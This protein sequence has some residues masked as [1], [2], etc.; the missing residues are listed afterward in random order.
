[1]IFGVIAN[2]GEVIVENRIGNSMEDR[3]FLIAFGA[4]GV[5]VAVYGAFLGRLSF[6]WGRRLGFIENQCYQCGYD[7]SGSLSAGREN[8]PECGTLCWRYWRH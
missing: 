8:C 2:I 7:L 6:Q 1:M 5:A 4:V 3:L